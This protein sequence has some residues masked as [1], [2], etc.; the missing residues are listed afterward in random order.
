MLNSETAIKE[1]PYDGLTIKKI[2]QS[3]SAETLLISLEMG[4]HLPEHSTA[5]PA[6]L[7]LLEG[8]ISFEIHNEQLILHSMDTFHIPKKVPHTVVGL[9]NAKFL[10]IR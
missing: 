6:L 5:K 2:L 3:D 9:S 7:I 4:H 10:I 1:I 8:T